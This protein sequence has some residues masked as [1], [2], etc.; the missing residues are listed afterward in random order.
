MFFKAVPV[1]TVGGLGETKV[2]IPHALFKVIV[3]EDNDEKIVRGFLFP[4]PSYA[5]VKAIMQANGGRIPAMGYRSCRF[6]DQ[7]T[8][9]FTGYRSSLSAIESLT[10]LQ[11]FPNVS[12]SEKEVLDR[13]LSSC[14]PSLSLMP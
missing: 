14:C 9:N 2:P 13:A 6:T 3:F 12:S 4:Q 7:H 5:M 11:F 1:E 10:G 8:Y